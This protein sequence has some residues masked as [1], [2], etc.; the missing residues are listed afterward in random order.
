MT[1]L[2]IPPIIEGWI[3][4]LHSKY[5]KDFVKENHRMMMEN[6]IEVLQEELKKYKR[7]K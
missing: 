1:K 5:E 3:E 7:L 2:N 4:K 6:L